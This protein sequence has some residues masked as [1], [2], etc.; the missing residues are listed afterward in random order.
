MIEPLNVKSPT[1]LVRVRAAPKVELIAQVLLPELV[2][3]PF[4]TRGFPEM[5]KPP[6]LKFTG[7]INV[8]IS[9][10]FARPLAPENVSVSPF[11]GPVPPQL[12][13][14]DQFASVP[15]PCQVKVLPKSTVAEN[16][17]LNNIAI[18]QADPD[19]GKRLSLRAATKFKGQ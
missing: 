8:R 1:V 15:D 2:K 18:R 3:F 19:F 12:A 9:L 7:P 13:I 17:L 6:L 5:L 16:G 14:V 11:E 10:M 4:R